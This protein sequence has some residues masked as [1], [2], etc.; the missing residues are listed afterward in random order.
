M[1]A[2]RNRFVVALGVL[3]AL[4]VSLVAPLTS[5]DSAAAAPVAPAALATDAPVTSVSLEPYYP[6]EP[7]WP[8]T[9]FPTF[10]QRIELADAAPVAGRTIDID[11]SAH[12]T[13]AAEEGAILDAADVELARYEVS[14]DGS[15]ISITYTEHVAAVVDLELALAV[16]VSADSL[17]VG[18]SQ[19]VTGEATVGDEAFA[20]SAQYTGLALNSNGLIGTWRTGAA[21]E[22]QLVSR[23][24]VES[25]ASFAAQGG[26]WIGVGSASYWNGS[27]EPVSGTTRVFAH[28][29]LPEDISTLTAAGAELQ[30]GTDY[31]LDE[32]QS[33][34][35]GPVF[36]I[37]IEHPS[38]GYIVVEQVYDLVQRGAAYFD[39]PNPSLPVAARP[40]FGVGTRIVTGTVNAHAA[41]SAN[42]G[43]LSALAYLPSSG[44]TAH[45]TEM[46]LELSAARNVFPQTAPAGE[47]KGTVELTISNTGN[48]AIDVTLTDRATATGAQIELS[49]PAADLGT[50]STS[51]G[52]AQWQGQ[53]APGDVATITYA[54]AARAAGEATGSV[55]FAGT[56][57]GAS[58]TGSGA[59]TTAVVDDASVAV[60]PLPPE[61]PNPTNPPGSGQ[62]LP[63]TGAPESVPTL[64]TGLTLIVAAA[65]ALAAAHVRRRV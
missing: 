32:Q 61:E 11:L 1:R 6:G 18:G 9:I 19:T 25:Q 42:V 50:V 14:A 36:G 34:D 59:T 44:G 48:A 40:V 39:V 21:G 41:G 49:S 28:A 12:L 51:G 37:S 22:L 53:L 60:S 17:R 33:H 54:F 16:L 13:A 2:A 31:V 62:H 24:V 55:T 45:A 38:D 46:H 52:A 56:I 47:A 63:R 30:Q 3:A 23:G 4:T 15:R 65:C 58:S 10:A 20:L 5:A 35:G 29:Q 27:V 43:G 7:S 64:I 26:Q 8:S 57:A